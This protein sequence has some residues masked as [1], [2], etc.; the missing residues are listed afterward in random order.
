MK[1]QPHLH[2]LCLSRGIG[3]NVSELGLAPEFLAAVGD[4]G[5][6]KA[7]HG[8]VA[9]FTLPHDKH[10]GHAVSFGYLTV[11][12]LDDAE[13]PAEVCCLSQLCEQ[14]LV[15]I[16]NGTL[17]ITGK[18]IIIFDAAVPFRFPAFFVVADIVFIIVS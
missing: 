4:P 1:F 12:S 5:L 9:V 11:F 16:V 3:K 14:P 18:Q 10:A 13:L 7:H 8:V 6:F 17:I 2:R 15:D